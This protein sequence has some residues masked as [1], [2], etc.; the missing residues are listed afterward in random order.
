[1]IQ[2]LNTT[3]DISSI[4]RDTVEEKILELQDKKLALAESI[5]REDQNV[6]RTLTTEDLTLLLS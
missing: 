4:A 3:F 6:M 2:S 1:M 5:I